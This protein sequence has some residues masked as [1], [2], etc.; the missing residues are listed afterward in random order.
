MAQVVQTFYATGNDKASLRQRS[1]LR[2]LLVG[3]IFAWFPYAGLGIGNT[4]QI[5][6][7][8]IACSLLLLTHLREARTL[9]LIITL[10]APTLLGLLTVSL[11]FNY[12]TLNAALLWPL[13]VLSFFSMQSIDLSNYRV[14]L[15]RW[16]RRLMLLASVF[17]LIQYV[18]I[19]TSGR[20]L[21]ASAYN[22]NGY[23]PL[24]EVTIAGYSSR[25]LGWF[26]EPSLLAVAMS[27][28]A[29]LL[30][31]LTENHLSRAD[32][33]LILLSLGM[34]AFAKS[35]LILIITPLIIL[36]T[37]RLLPRRRQLVGAFVLTPAILVVIYLLVWQ[38]R[39]AAI[40]TGR[41]FSWTDRWYSI[42]ISIQAT[43]A[44]LQ[45]FLIGFGPGAGATIFDNGYLTVDS[46]KFHSTPTDI[47]SIWAR[48]VVEIGWPVAALIMGLLLRLLWKASQAAGNDRILRLSVMFGWLLVGAFS[49]SYTQFGLYW[50]VGG[51]LA[52]DPSDSVRAAIPPTTHNFGHTADE[53]LLAG[54]PAP[55]TSHA[56][57]AS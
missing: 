5:T 47:F 14:H 44:S 24:S 45:H 29:L 17:A 48:L 38:S 31:H 54:G 8:M 28:G 46:G 55:T 36:G 2:L 52:N 23:A 20:M 53:R 35:G 42:V 9:A 27:L 1:T 43:F 49:L 6:V 37:V 39:G 41:N 22:L 30:I 25:L 18:V 21:L 33:L 15:A 13:Y 10:F 4:G 40:S 7:S 16:T 19:N 51:L 56:R 26:P 3:F 32:Q 57:A 12:A 34:S 11:G 50:V